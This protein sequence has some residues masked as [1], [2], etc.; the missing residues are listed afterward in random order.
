MGGALVIL[1]TGG[2]CFSLDRMLD[3]IAT[4][5]PLGRKRARRAVIRMNALSFSLT[6]RTQFDLPISALSEAGG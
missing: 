2:G 1:V 6:A 4:V 5:R 3:D